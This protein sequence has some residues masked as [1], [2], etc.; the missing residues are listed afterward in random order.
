MTKELQTP[1]FYDGT[2]L[3][4]LSDINGNKPE[5]F[6]CTSNRSAGK[7]TY[8]GRMLVNN[9]L[10]HDRKFWTGL[11]VKNRIDFV[12]ELYCSKRVNPKRWSKEWLRKNNFPDRP[13]Y[14]MFYQHGNKANMIRGKADV[15]VDDS[16]GNVEKC[17]KSGFPALWYKDHRSPNDPPF[18][19]YSLTKSEIISTFTNVYK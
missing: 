12:P 9:F 15:L 5:I 19:I 17:I 2:K 3:L 11:D 4:S 8:F 7:T 16:Y 18:T 10:K 6:L 14:Q 1:T 13:F